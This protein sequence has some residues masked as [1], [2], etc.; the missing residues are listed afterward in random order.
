[1]PLCEP[2]RQPNGTGKGKNE[3]TRQPIAEDMP[4]SSIWNRSA[5]Q[6]TMNYDS[7]DE[8]L[9]LWA[10]INGVT[11]QTRYKDDEVRAF[12][13]WSSDNQQKAQVGV[14]DLTDITV[15]LTVF[16]GKKKREKIRGTLDQIA[17][18]LDEAS[19]L[20]RQ[21]IGDEPT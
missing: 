1:M 3:P 11:V 4:T 16:D 21:W 15:E 6:I 14:S 8:E 5:F 18:L 17:D 13:I 20:A 7:I 9:K 2:T 19:C 12:E 10:S